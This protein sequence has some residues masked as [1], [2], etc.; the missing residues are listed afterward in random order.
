MVMFDEPTAALGIAQRRTTLNL[1]RAVADQGVAV[2][3]ISHNLEDIFAVSDR[4]VALRLGEV[5]LDTPVSKAT[6]ED[7]LTC[8]TMGAQAR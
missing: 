3:V 4:I 6:H 2:I 1:V 5:S 8:M 7:V